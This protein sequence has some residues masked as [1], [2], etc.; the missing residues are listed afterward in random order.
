MAYKHIGDRIRE[1]RMER[2]L[3]QEKTAKMFNV[4]RSTWCQYETGI[5]NIDN[6]TM[7]KIAQ[8]F[9]V[10]ADYLLGITEERYDSR[11]EH[12]IKFIKFYKQ[13]DKDKRDGFIKKI[14]EIYGGI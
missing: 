9:N 11:N 14:E 7:K 10:S 3:T 13:I 2:N 5:R 6:I 1:L 4:A 12:L 8:V